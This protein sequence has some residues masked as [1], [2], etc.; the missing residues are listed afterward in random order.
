MSMT[1]RFARAVC[2]V[3]ALAFSLAA[4][5]GG[6]GGTAAPTAV[7]PPAGGGGGEGQIQVVDIAFEPKR[8][9]IEAGEAVAWS[10][11]GS[12]P[13]SVTADDG[14]FDSDI[15][16]KGSTFEQTFD[17]P[18]KYEYYCKVHSSPDGDTQNGVIVVE[19]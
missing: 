6:D 8:V 5:G 1:S 11:E 10:W 15:Q 3:S 7:S 14:S 13:H 17:E 9:T 12:Q 19:G 18:G 16:E 4:C 2:L